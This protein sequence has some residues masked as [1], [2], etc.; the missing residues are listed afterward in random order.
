MKILIVV[1]TVLFYF[2][3][4]SQ[5]KKINLSIDGSLFSQNMG[6]IRWEMYY[7]FP[8]NMLKYIKNDSSFI[9]EIYFDVKFINSGILKYEK[10]WVIPH[11]V[12]SMDSI[13]KE[14][15]FGTKSFILA[16]GQ[17]KVEINVV[18]VNNDKSKGKTE[19]EINAVKFK[20]DQIDLSSLQLANLIVNVDSSAIKFDEMFE[21]FNLYVI[22]NPSLEYIGKKTKLIAYSEIYNAKKISPDGFKIK[23]KIYDAAKREIYKLEV[24][25]ESTFDIAP[26]GVNISLNNMPTGVYYFEQT[27][28]YP[29]DN[30]TDSVSSTKKYYLLNPEKGPESTKYFTENELFA[31]SPFATLDDKR[32]DDEIKKACVISDDNELNQMKKLG[33]KEAKQRYLFLFWRLK[34][35]DTTTVVNERYEDFYKA[36]KYANMYFQTSFRQGWETDRGKVMLKY[37]FPTERKEHDAM[38]GN[39]AYEEWFFENVQGGSFFYF[40]DRSS[41]NNFKLYHSTAKGEPYNSDWFNDYVPHNSLKGQQPDSKYMND[42]DYRR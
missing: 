6:N 30:P 10:Q 37:G 12:N 40:V 22:P 16:P 39:N 24:M 29:K 3:G 20:T 27:V 23:Y 19:F 14:I 25:R 11:S 5:E 18:D 21:K 38:Y 31:Q 7:C 8:D 13:N 17:Y 34:D 41:L 4:Y 26:E 32:A 1:F 9:S 42:D 15:I 2:Q 35:P 36:I 28:I 33:T